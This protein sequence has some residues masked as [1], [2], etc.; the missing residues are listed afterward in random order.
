MSGFLWIGPQSS[1]LWQTRDTQLIKTAWNLSISKSASSPIVRSRLSEDIKKW[2]GHVF[3]LFAILRK[4][5]EMAYFDLSKFCLKVPLNGQQR[6]TTCFATLLQNE[7]N[8]D[9]P[10]FTAHVQTCL[11]TNQVV[12][13]VVL[14][15]RVCCDTKSCLILATLRLYGIP[16]RDVV[17]VHCGTVLGDAYLTWR[18]IRPFKTVRQCTFA[19]ISTR[20]PAQPQSG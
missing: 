18:K 4:D 14:P 11:A 3:Y 13:K 15:D 12:A 6:R 17:K 20:S 5:W 9:G 8:S 7:L 1:K 10:W 19:T 2:T 16:G